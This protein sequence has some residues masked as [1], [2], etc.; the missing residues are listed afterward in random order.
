MGCGNRRNSCSN[1]GFWA[2]RGGAA[3]AATRPHRVLA[4]VPGGV[5]R[6]RQ[7]RHSHQVISPGH[8]V[9]PRLRPLQSPIP[10][11]P[12]PAHRLDP[13]E[14]F[15]HPLSNFQT[16]LITFLERRAP[17]QARHF[18]F[19]FARDVRRDLSFPAALHKS[20]LMIPLVRA[21]RF[22]VHAG[23]QLRVRVHLAQGHDRFRFSDRIVQREVGA[24][25]VPVFHQR[26]RAKTQPGGGPVGFPIEH[27]VRIRRAVM[28]VVAALFPAKVDRRIAG[29]FVFGGL[30]LLCIRPICADE[31]FQARPRFDQRAFGGEVFI[32]P[33]TGG[34]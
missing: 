6:R 19:L 5:S 26:V 21:H 30:D 32:A 25:P 11:P 12:E 10:A 29:I 9:A 20:L 13:A 28:R 16:H 31:T 15:F 24:Q 8:E 23:G 27:A 22:D 34:A 14:N 17:V 2:A 1:R 7:S 18:Y 4:P 33:P 3:S